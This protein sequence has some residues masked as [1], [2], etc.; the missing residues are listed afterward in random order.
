VGGFLAFGAKKPPLFFFHPYGCARNLF[1]KFF[2][3]H[4]PYLPFPEG[5]GE[6][7]VSVSFS[8]AKPPKNSLKLFTA[9]TPQSGVDFAR[10]GGG[11]A[12]TLKF[13]RP[14]P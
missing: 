12:S 6:Q 8:A 10:V 5:R 13:G 3:T 4:P 2:S 9:P 1:V 7:E 14:F 11:V